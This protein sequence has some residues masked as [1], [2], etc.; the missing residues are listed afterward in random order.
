MTARSG[1]RAAQAVIGLAPVAVGA[2]RVALAGEG[3]GVVVA[4]GG[5][6]FN[7]RDEFHDHSVLQRRLPRQALAN[8][9]HDPPRFARATPEWPPHRCQ[10]RGAQW[11]GL[12]GFSKGVSPM[13]AHTAVSGCLVS[14]SAAPHRW[15]PQLFNWLAVLVLLSLGVLV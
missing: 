8:G 5:L 1:R 13:S 10:L 11:T 2:H 6:V 7:D 15:L 4:N 9:R 3:G 14:S 12:E